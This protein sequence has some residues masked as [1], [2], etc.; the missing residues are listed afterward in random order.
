MA[1]LG[2]IIILPRLLFAFWTPARH[3]PTF[4]KRPSSSSTGC[5]LVRVRQVSK[6]GVMGLAHARSTVVPC[7]PALSI[8]VQSATS[9]CH[10][11]FLCLCRSHEASYY[12]QAIPRVGPGLAWPAHRPSERTCVDRGPEREISTYFLWPPQ[13]SWR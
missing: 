7:L 3:T 1:R 2:W 13:N 6:S 10:L 9:H 12:F 5:L 8:R 4:E 11:P